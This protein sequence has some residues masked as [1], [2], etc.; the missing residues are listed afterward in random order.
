[1]FHEASLTANM[2]DYIQAQ[3]PDLPMKFVSVEFDGYAI[4]SNAS[5]KSAGFSQVYENCHRTGWSA[6]FKIGY[7][8]MCRFWFM[9]FLKYVREY[10]W[11]LRL[12]P[13]CELEE[14]MRGVLPLAEEVFISSPAWQPLHI[15]RFDKIST[16]YD[17]EVVRG[18]GPFTREYYTAHVKPREGSG[19]FIDSWH[20]PYTNAMY[21]NLTA[22]HANATWEARTVWGFLR[23]VDLS[24]CIYSN[25]W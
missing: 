7:K 25:R 6:S 20:A 9:G 5:D 12:D 2:Q 10:N 4:Y 21:M 14:D 19:E 22:L 1:M 3:T 11:I 15:Q 16:T 18:M 13:D 24:N 23:A 8:N 17:G